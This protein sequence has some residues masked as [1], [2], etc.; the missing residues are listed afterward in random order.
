PPGG[1]PRARAGQTD[2]G[3]AF[4]DAL[5][6]SVAGCRRHGVVPGIHA[7]GPLTP[8]RREQGFRMITVTSDALAMKAGFT[9]ELAAARGD[10]A[11][12]GSGAMY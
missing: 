1:A 11:G 6:T 2:G 10:G 8:K 3:A 5:A 4:D 9:S 7:T 12:S